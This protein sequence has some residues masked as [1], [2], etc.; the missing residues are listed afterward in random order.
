MHIRLIGAVRIEA[1]GTTRPVTAAK[2]AAA[3]AA[4]AA[5]PGVPVSR[6]DLID[7]VWGADPPTGV[8]SSLYSYVT[9]LRTLMQGVPSTVRRSGPNGYVLDASP[10]HIDVHVVRALAAEAAELSGAGRREEALRRLRDAQALADGTALSGIPGTWAA[11]FRTAFAAERVQLLTNRYGAEL[12]AGNHEAVLGELAA[13]AEAEPLAE[14]LTG[15]LM[16]ARYRAGRPADA[17]AV[18]ERMRVRLR[19]ELGADPS[20]ELQRLH[21]RILKQDPAIDAAPAVSRPVPAMLPAGISGFVGRRR[22]LAAVSTELGG[23]AEATLAVVGPGGAGKTAFAVHWGQSHRPD[24]PDGQLYVN[25]R[26]FDRDSPLAPGEA[27][28]RFLLAL[29]HPGDDIPSDVDTAAELYRSLTSGRRMLVVLDNA[30][31]VE[32]VRQLLPGAGCATIVTS[33]N[34]LAGLIAVDHVRTVAMP[35]LPDD[36]SVEVL[37]AVLGDERVAAEP[38]AAARLAGLC[39]HLPLALRIA[40]ADLAV[41]PVA[42]IAAHAEALAGAGRLGLLAIPGDRRAAVSANL[43]LSYRALPAAAR[44]LLC[45]L[46]TLPTEDMTRGLVEAVSGLSAAECAGALAALHDGHLVEEHREGR[47][48]MHD[49]VALY[50][51]ARAETDLSDDERTRIV[52]AF[53]EWHHDRAYDLDEGEVHNILLAASRLGEHPRLW[54][55]VVPLRKAMNAGRSLEQVRGAATAA[56]RIAEHGADEAGTFQMSKL[57]A[58]VHCKEGDMPTALELG[59][60]VVTMAAALGPKE[61]AAAQGNL[62]AFRTYAGDSRGAVEASSGALD[63]AIANGIIPSQLLIIESLVNVLGRI[64]D[65]RRALD[66]IAKIEALGDALSPLHKANLRLHTA[67]VYI[68]EGRLDEAIALLDDSVNVAR[69]EGNTHLELRAHIWLG[70][71]HR[72]AG[73][74]AEARDA[75]LTELELGLR[76]GGS[77][78]VFDTLTSLAHVDALD[79][80]PATAERRLA[81]ARTYAKHAASPVGK[82]V[83]LLVQA[84]IHHARGEHHEAVDAAGS[85]LS[86]YAAMPWLMRQAEALDVLAAAHEALGDAAEARRCREEA[87][88]LVPNAT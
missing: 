23:D 87:A 20:T 17:L 55:L 69:R 24:F 81:E 14:A 62:G 33:R 84:M 2:L 54:R 72:R 74:L 85:A 38:E 88:R 47:Y 11:G 13:L 6:L 43:E 31:D 67:R 7:R 30:R 68:E 10:E 71:A 12:E 50:A 66:Y 52:D 4:L 73:R 82:P 16:L 18:F 76:D 57:L 40:A 44:D 46:G 3:L 58:N 25:L 45:R 8:M 61:L 60:K 70:R 37:A 21:V 86:A 34:R 5:E 51:A 83:L 75:H 59:E 64:G 65:I 15:H 22:E 63:L 42:S 36:E 78:T 48:R 77:P 41:R 56:L 79:G 27:L 32:Q 19:D 39:D 80:D 35:V 28:G 26:G 1:G 9:R 53:I 49:L 29:G